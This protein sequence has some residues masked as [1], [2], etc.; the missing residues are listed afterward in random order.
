[1]PLPSNINI[2]D[3]SSQSYLSEFIQSQNV[4]NLKQAFHDSEDT[5]TLARFMATSDKFAGNYLNVIPNDAFGTELLP[6]EFRMASLYRLGI[7]L[8]D[9]PTATHNKPRCINCAKPLDPC[10]DH[11]LSCAFGGGGLITRYDA[12]R[13]IVFSTCSQAHYHPKK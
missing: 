8:L 4:L 5:S 12:L 7:T 11:A 13:D 1:M 2:H 9:N 3:C 6:N 10:G